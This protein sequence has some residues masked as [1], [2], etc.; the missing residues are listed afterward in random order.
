MQVRVR[1]LLSSQETSNYWQIQI[2][3]TDGSYGKR[4][5]TVIVM[6]MV[7]WYFLYQNIWF[8]GFLDQLIVLMSR[9]AGKFRRAISHHEKSIDEQSE[10]FLFQ[11]YRLF[12][13]TF[14]FLFQLLPV[15][16]SS[17]SLVTTQSSLKAKRRSPTVTLSRRLSHKCML[18]L[19]PHLSHWLDRQWAN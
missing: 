11:I 14:M 4:L 19:D 1:H 17:D 3:L 8:R 9:P 12:L 18:I 2:K 6:S 15:V 7:T 10:R 13:P 16:L 5:T